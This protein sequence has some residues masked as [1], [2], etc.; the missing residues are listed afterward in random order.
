MVI[1]SF[2]IIYMLCIY[3]IACHY[4]ANCHFKYKENDLKKVF[5]NVR[6]WLV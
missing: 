4:I 3:Y 6:I 1:Y 2:V 5:F